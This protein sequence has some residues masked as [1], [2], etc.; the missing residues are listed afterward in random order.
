MIRKLGV[1]FLLSACGSVA[2]GMSEPAKAPAVQVVP[3]TSTTTIAPTTTVKP[4][5]FR[6]SEPVGLTHDERVALAR[7]AHGVCG[8][9]RNLAL[10]VGWPESEWP[11]LNYIIWRESRC[12]PWADSGPDHG[13]T[14]INRIHTDWLAMMGWTH[15]D[16]YVPELN[17]T[18]AYR[19]W[20]T[21]GWRPWGFDDDFTPPS[22]D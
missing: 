6:D 8:E 15:E 14:Q 2:H 10:A 4:A 12:L 18:F 20:E 9:W 13:L 7:Q 22:I 3:T 17:L 21:S 5:V 16:M 19:L 11:R 1:V